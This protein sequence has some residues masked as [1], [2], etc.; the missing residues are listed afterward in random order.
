MLELTYTDE[1][2]HVLNNMLLGEFMLNRNMSLD[3]LQTEDC[4]QNTSEHFRGTG[5]QLLSVKVL[6]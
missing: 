4:T 3:A 1:Q 2:L 6:W 5:R